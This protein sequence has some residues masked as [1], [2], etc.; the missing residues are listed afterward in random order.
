MITS[1][2]YAFVEHKGDEDW[3]VK[4]KE[5]DYKDIIYK[6]GKIG[7]QEEGDEARLRFQFKVAKLPPDFDMTEEDLNQDETFLNHLGDVLT[8]ILEDAMDSGQYKLGQNDKPTD[9][10]PTVHE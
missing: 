2:S 3:Y 10:E 6:Y 8:H 5:G 9:S 1:K 4:L 7:F